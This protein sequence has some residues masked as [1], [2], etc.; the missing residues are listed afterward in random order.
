M[1]N[2]LDNL[3][4]RFQQLMQ[5]RYGT[6]EFNRFLSFFA[7][8]LIIISFFRWLWPP[9]FY[10]DI[11]ALLILAYAIFRSFSRNHYARSKER[12]FYVNIKDKVLGFFRLQKKRWDGRAT[13]RY[14]RCPGCRTIIRVP[15]GR[16]KIE[17]TCP[18]CRNRFIKRT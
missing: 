2:F 9:L 13:S 12:D 10:V 1:R 14:Y 7:L 16:G 17:I 8:G 18:K 3:R 6:D 15:K 4:Y 5:G 11:A